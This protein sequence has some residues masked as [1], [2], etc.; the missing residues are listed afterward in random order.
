MITPPWNRMVVLCAVLCAML[1]FT[2]CDRPVPPP[3]PVSISSPH[4][5]DAGAATPDECLD[6]LLRESHLNAFG[7][8]PD[9]VYPGGSPLLDERTGQ[10]T[11]RRDYIR[12]H[13]PEIVRRCPAGAP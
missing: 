2:A 12:S 1:P 9:T 10:V 6:R 13:H 5:P 11:S 3:A 7:D 4:P 8:P